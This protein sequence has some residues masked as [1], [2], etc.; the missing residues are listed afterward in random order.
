MIS[1]EEF[2]ADALR[3]FKLLDVTK[4]GV[5]ND[6]EIQRYEYQI[7]PE[8]VSAT[9][10]TSAWSLQ[11]NEDANGNTKNS[12]LAPMRQGAAN[13]SFLNDAEPVRSADTDLNRKVTL[14][15]WKAAADHRFNRL[16]PD[17]AEGL[18]L[19]DLPRPPNQRPA[20]K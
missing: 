7:A 11:K 3:F 8:I 14:D 6:L 13:F 4:D 17:G 12:V 5:I 10:D 18:K 20:A 2:R 9:Q 1:R 16:L 19:A 15:E